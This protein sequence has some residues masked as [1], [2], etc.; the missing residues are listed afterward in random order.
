MEERLQKTLARAGLGSRR[1]C[2][3]LIQQGRVTV[4]GQTAQ[5]GQK[6]DPERDRIAVDSKPIRLKQ[7]HTYIA[8]HKPAGVVC[9]TR[10]PQG[11]PTVVDLVPARPGVRLWPVGRLDVDSEGLVLLTDDGELTHRLTHPHF[12]HE[13]EYRV[14]VIGRPARETLDQLRKGIV[15]DGQRTAPAQVRVMRQDS[16]NSWWLHIVLH[17]GRKRQI[18]RMLQVVDHPVKRLI[19][20]RIGA[21]RLGDLEPS[22]WRRLTAQEVRALLHLSRP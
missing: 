2:E 15:L 11:R 7:H 22:Q 4:N 13:K 5:L 14:L 6:A 3:E 16:Q 1:A 10:D 19:R 8:L 17:E 9:T 20:V 21:L 18:R 12:Q